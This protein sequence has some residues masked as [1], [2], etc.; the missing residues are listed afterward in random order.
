MKHQSEKTIEKEGQEKVRMIFQLALGKTV[1]HYAV[2]AYQQQSKKEKEDIQDP[3]KESELLQK[4]KKNSNLI[5]RE[6]L[7]RSNMRI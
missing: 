1:G 5:Q 7:G 6:S 3:I 4:N 2:K